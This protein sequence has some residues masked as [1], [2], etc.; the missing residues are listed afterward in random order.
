VTKLMVA[1]CAV[2]CVSACN[3]QRVT[4]STSTQPPIA[5]PPGLPLPTPP[6]VVTAWD[7]D[8]LVK[9]A[10]GAGACGRLIHTG[11]T[12][13]QVTWQLT[14]TGGLIEL[15]EDPQ[16]FPNDN[17]IFTGTTDGDT[18]GAAESLVNLNLD[19]RG[20]C[21]LRRS[22]LAGNFSADRLAFDATETELWG[23]PNGRTTIV[24]HW[25]ASKRQ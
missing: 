9:S 11:E 25:S 8:V 21:D 18:F 5:P 22:D 3:A 12:R 2:V 20:A 10:D 1:A 19:A 17:I 15:I 13:E 14:I 7:A 4:G 24:R 6:A 23:P 16:P